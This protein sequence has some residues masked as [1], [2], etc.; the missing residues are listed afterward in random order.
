MPICSYVVLPAKGATTRLVARLATLPGC[1]VARADRHD[2][3]LLV[4]DTADPEEERRLTETLGGVPEIAAM[5]LAFG[6]VEG[7][8]PS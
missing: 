1:Q 2:A 7:G 8:T 5:M 4:T 6:Q 3:L